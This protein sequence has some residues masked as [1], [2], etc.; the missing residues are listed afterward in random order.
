[1]K[2]TSYCFLLMAVGFFLLN[3][4]KDTDDLTKEIVG[5]YLGQYSSNSS[6]DFNNYEINIS[7]VTDSRIL[8]APKN[9]NE[10]ESWETDLERINS[11]NISAPVG[12]I[13]PA[14]VF[15]LGDPTG[16]TFQRAN[17]GDAFV[18]ELK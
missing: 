5:V 12:Q 13:D 8:I 15:T 9:G 1:M 17:E 7:K 11:S 10:F 4:C 16:M 18:G 2:M 3:S 14:V 6:G